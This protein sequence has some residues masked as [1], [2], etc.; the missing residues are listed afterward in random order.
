MA[1]KSKDRVPFI[2][3]PF[4]QKEKNYE[5]RGDDKMEHYV[6]YVSGGLV[7]G[8]TYEAGN[9]GKSFLSPL[10]ELGEKTVLIENAKTNKNDSYHQY[11][12]YSD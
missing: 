3:V 10:K 1:S 6:Y 11:A 9:T 7:D 4:L 12:K 2:S 5:A 8:R